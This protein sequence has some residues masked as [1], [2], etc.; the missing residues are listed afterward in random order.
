MNN[1]QLYAYNDAKIRAQQ[2]FQFSL[3]GETAQAQELLQRTHSE[4]KSLSG[5]VLVTGYNR[6]QEE[7][8]DTQALTRTFE[9]TQAWGW[10]EL[11]SGIFQIMRDRP[12]TS[13]VYFKRAWR[14]WR[15]WSTNAVSEVQRYEAKRERARTGLW[16]GEA[17]A[18][19]MSDR[20]QQSANAILRAALTEL[21]RIEAYDLLQET[22]DQQSL[23]PPAPPGSLAYNNGRHI[24]YICLFFTQSAFLEQLLYSRR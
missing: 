8:I 18:R 24:P 23:L 2:A 13:M 12:G 7:S 1:P 14:I 10:F 22:I 5:D 15:P 9:Q 16:L 4:L 6:V 19:F 11:A 17:W 20:A 3:Q 21:L